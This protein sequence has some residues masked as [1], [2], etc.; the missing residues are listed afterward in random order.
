MM[1]KVSTYPV[2]DIDSDHNLPAM[3]AK[4]EHKTTFDMSKLGLDVKSKVQ[5]L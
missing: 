5:I 2:A 4:K 1:K 3:T